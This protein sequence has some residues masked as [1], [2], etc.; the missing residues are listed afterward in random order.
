M[1]RL[2]RPLALCALLSLGGCGTTFMAARASDHHTRLEPYSGTMLDLEGMTHGRGLG[3]FRAVAFLDFPLS[4][5]ADTA[6]LPV[7]FPWAIC[8]WLGY[9]PERPAPEPAPTQPS[10]PREHGEARGAADWNRERSFDAPREV[11]P[12][13]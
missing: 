4:L 10:P 9:H 5:V 1:T 11:R 8:A 3:W 6:V 7:T 13:R 12:G 2:L